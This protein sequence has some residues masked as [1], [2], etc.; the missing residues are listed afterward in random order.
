MQLVMMELINILENTYKK[1]T[2]Y[3]NCNEIDCLKDFGNIENAENIDDVLRYL[4]EINKNNENEKYDKEKN[5]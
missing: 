3:L 5:F 4:D 1:K 2:L